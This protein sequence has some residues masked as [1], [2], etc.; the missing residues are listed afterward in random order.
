MLPEA[1]PENAQ[2][3]YYIDALFTA[4]SATCVTG[5]VVRDTGGNFTPFGQGVILV[6][7]QLGGLGIMIFGTMMAMLMGKGL[8]VR[9]SSALGEMVSVEGI[10]LTSA[11][12]R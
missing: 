1:V 7:I 9:G 12:A 8:S 3:P 2:A 11:F 10:G 5:L 4:T 6:L